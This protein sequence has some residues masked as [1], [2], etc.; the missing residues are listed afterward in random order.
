MSG[1]QKK[2]DC[3]NYDPKDE[4]KIVDAEPQ[5]G[6]YRIVKNTSGDGIVSYSPQQ[7][8]EANPYSIWASYKTWDCLDVAGTTL[9][10]AKK[11]IEYYKWIDELKKCTKDII[12]I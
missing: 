2:D 12:E 10:N 5:I 1:C 7:Y 6:D 11:I 9:E 4:T 3:K 8:R